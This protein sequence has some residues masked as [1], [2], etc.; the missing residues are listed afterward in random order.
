ME[1]IYIEEVKKGMKKIIFVKWNEFEPSSPV[2]LMEKIYLDG[3]HV[4]TVRL[5]RF[6]P[7]HFLAKFQ[8]ETQ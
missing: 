1:N 4:R 2:W 6:S 5:G 7:N 3:V 8:S